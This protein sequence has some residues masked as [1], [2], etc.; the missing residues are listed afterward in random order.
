MKHLI[1]LVCLCVLLAGCTTTAAPAKPEEIK[2]ISRIGIASIVGDRIEYMRIGITAFTNS[3]TSGD[4]SG[5][6]IDEFVLGELE[7]QLPSSYNTVRVNMDRSAYEASTAKTV[8][9]QEN[10]REA[11]TPGNEDVDAYLVLVPTYSHDFISGSYNRMHGLGIFRRQ[12][13]GIRVYAICDLILLDAQSFE[14]LGGAQLAFDGNKPDLRDVVTGRNL[15]SVVLAERRT[16]TSLS[17]AANWD[18]FTPEQHEQIR[19]S[20]TSLLRD[21]LDYPIRAIG[22]HK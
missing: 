1:T 3:T 18:E 22:L 21:A 4:T 12:G 9:I 15:R 8:H 17:A 5:W 11:I 20:I 19:T 13:Y 10:I 7:T 6:G 2:R 16:V 14:L